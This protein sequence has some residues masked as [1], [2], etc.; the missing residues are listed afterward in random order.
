MWFSLLKCVD[1]NK[2]AIISK[3][4]ILNGFRYEEI[5]EEKEFF[6]VTKNS[7]RVVVHFYRSDAFR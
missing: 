5:P 6:N 4:L 7:E 3:T 2:L 1:S